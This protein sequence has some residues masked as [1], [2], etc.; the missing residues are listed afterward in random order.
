M[1]SGLIYIIIVGMWIAYFL[2]RWIAN[3]EEVSGR[4]VEKFALTMKV[5]GRTAGKTSVN[6]NE[7][8]LRHEQQI[9]V[10]RILFFSIMSFMAIT[11]IFILVGFLS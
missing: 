3:H 2:P 7:I 11:S 9:L 4:S 8:K 6:I 1:A 10:R 5:V